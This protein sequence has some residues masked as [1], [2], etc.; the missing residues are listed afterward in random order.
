MIVVMGLCFGGFQFE[1]VLLILVVSVK[2]VVLF[3][4][5]NVENIIND[6]L[7]FVFSVISVLNNLGGGVVIVDL[8]GLGLMCMFVLVDGWWYVV[9]DL[10]QVVDFNI[11]FVGLIDWIDIVIGGCL[12]VYGLD[13]VVGVVNFVMKCDFSGV[14]V[15][16]NYCINQVG[17]GGIL[18]SN[19]LLGG[20]FVDGCGNVMIY[21]DFIKC[22]SILQGSCDYLCQ[23]L[24]DDGNGGLIVGGLG[25]IEGICFVI[26]GVNCKF[27][28]DGSYMFYKVVIDVYNYVFSNYLQ[29]LQKCFLMSVQ[30]YYEVSSV[31]NVYVEG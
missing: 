18:N 12:V 23:V 8:C 30:M 15:N 28:S 16:V 2:E 31:F 6:L 21:F 14:W 4:Q 26:G 9:Y 10:I 27:E 25:L 3:G 22:D 11:I 1:Q 17:D 19:I 7:Q 5:V 24:V 29:V 13:V 20:N